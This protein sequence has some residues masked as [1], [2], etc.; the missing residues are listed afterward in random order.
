METWVKHLVS[1]QNTINYPRLNL[2]ALS[3]R[4]KPNGFNSVGLC[5]KAFSYFLCCVTFALLVFGGGSSWI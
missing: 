3:Q 2:S 4:E 5:F 1:L